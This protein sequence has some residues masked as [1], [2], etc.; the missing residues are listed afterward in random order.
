MLQSLS[1]THTGVT[2]RDFDE[3]SLGPEQIVVDL[4][5]IP[6]ASDEEKVAI[7]RTPYNM[8]SAAISL[9]E[10]A[11]DLTGPGAVTRLYDVLASLHKEER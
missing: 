8:I 7:S 5:H 6:D 3:N 4:Y 9:I 1:I 11:V 10:E 2:M